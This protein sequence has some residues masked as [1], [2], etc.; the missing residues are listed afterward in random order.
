MYSSTRS[1]TSALDEGGWLRPRLDRF[2][3]G[4]YPVPILQEAGWA[5]GPVWT[6]VQNI[7]RPARTECAVQAH[8]VLE[9]GSFITT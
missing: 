5:Q 2:T 1:L 6:G 7:D 3:P 8:D 4:K 9:N